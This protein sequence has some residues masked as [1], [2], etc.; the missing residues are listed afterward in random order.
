MIIR[1][2]KLKDQRPFHEMFR[3]FQHHH[4]SARSNFFIDPKRISFSTEVYKQLIEDPQRGAFLAFEDKTVVGMLL[5]TI[6]PVPVGEL[7]YP[8]TRPTI[9]MLVVHENYRK[10]GVGKALVE[11]AYQW[12]R[13]H[14]YN[15][16]VTDVWEFSDKAKSL[17]L[18]EGFA[19]RTSRLFKQIA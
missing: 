9:E 14:G 2:A 8:R 6:C 12:S 1:P 5:V 7:Q 13:D 16:I 11:Q 17:F 15:E 10:H 4:F 18:K 19:V 3:L